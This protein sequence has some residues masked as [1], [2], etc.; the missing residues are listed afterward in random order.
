MD[1]AESSSGVT[2][3]P[4]AA[5]GATGTAIDLT[6][7][8]ELQSDALIASPELLAGSLGEYLRAWWQRTRSGESGALPV[9]VGLIL[10]VIFFQLENSVFLSSSNLVNLLVQAAVFVVLGVAEIFALVLSEIDL[11]VGFVSAIGGMVIAE[12]IA[13]PV[14]LPWW[15]GVIGGLGACAIIGFVQGSVITRLHVPSFIVTLAGLLIWEGVLIELANVDSTAVGG[16]ISLDPSSPIW[17]LVNAN[18]SPAA[19]WITLAAV[20]AVFALVQIRSSVR[21]RRQGLSAPPMS[22]TLATIGLTAIGGAAI[23]FVCNRNRGSLVTLE[24]VPYVVPFI[25]V[26]LLGWSLLLGRTRTGRYIYAIGASPEAAR[27]A[28]ISVPWVRTFAFTMCSFTA[29]IAGMIYLSRLS[30]ISIGYDGGSVVLYAVASAVIGGASLFG[31]RG[32]PLH[33]L[34]GALVIATVYNGLALLGITTWGQ[35]VA[36]GVVLLLAATVD[37]TLR[38]RGTTGAL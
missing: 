2:S 17:K 3:D 24:G 4:I 9:V 30:S 11:S 10:I 16:V 26:I 27:R 6:A 5:T 35:D 14:N 1:E 23:V 15:L 36:T 32:K 29:G 20:L 34:L 37:A 31:G 18:M 7:E 25:G 33:A 12:L 38:R 21:R 13:P 28:G 8:P 22:I 19:G